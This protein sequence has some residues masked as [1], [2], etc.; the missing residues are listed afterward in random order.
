M[1]AL[2]SPFKF[3]YFIHTGLKMLGGGLGAVA[4]IGIVTLIVYYATKASYDPN[5]H[6]SAEVQGVLERMPIID[7]WEKL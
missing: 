4:L 6:L 3:N 1:H 5:S 2:R 7:G